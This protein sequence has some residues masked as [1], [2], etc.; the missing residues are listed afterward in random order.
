MKRLQQYLS[1]L[2]KGLDSFPEAQTKA[3][4][5]HSHQSVSPIQQ[6]GLPAAMQ[7]L[8]AHLPPVNVWISSVYWVALGLAHADENFAYDDDAYIEGEKRRAETLMDTG[9]YKML[10][11]MTSPSVYVRSA[12]KRWATFHSGTELELTSVGKTHA[13]L[14]LTSPPGLFPRLHLRQVSSTFEYKTGYVANGAHVELQ[15]ASAGKAQFQFS[16]T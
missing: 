14:N 12:P 7:G 8:L 13:V 3:G 9:T 11:M 1:A 5:L 10:R 6:T 4:L 16:W 15:D 2:P